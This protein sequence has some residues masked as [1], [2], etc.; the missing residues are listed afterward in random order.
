[1]A[2]ARL[3]C[4]GMNLI[5]FPWN[6]TGL[7]FLVSG[8][9]GEVHAWKSFQDHGTPEDYRRPTALV[10]EGLFRYTRNPMHL[11]SLFMII[12]AATLSGNVLSF[13]TLPFLYIV[14]ETVFIPWEEE[15]MIKI[16][17][18]EYRCYMKTV[19]RWI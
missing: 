3:L 10:T 8:V 18:D 4:P 6:I 16:F 13:L 19:R 7:I 1:M 9:W 11:G 15:T 2:A 5:P 12:G 14:I 17:G